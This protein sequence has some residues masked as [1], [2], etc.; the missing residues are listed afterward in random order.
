MAKWYGISNFG[1]H[2][3]IKKDVPKNIEKSLKKLGFYGRIKQTSLTGFISGDSTNK[4]LAKIPPKFIIS[5]GGG[6]TDV[7]QPLEKK[8]RI[9]RKI[10]KILIDYE[11]PA[12]FLT[13]SKLILRD[14]D[15]IGELNDRCYAN[16]AFSITQAEEKT[17]LLLE[18]YSSSTEDRFQVLRDFR[19]ANISGGVCLMPLAPFI[20]DTKE[21]LNQLLQM[22]IENK[23]DYALIAGLTLK[24][25][26][27]EVFFNN[28]IK[29]HYPDLLDR[30]NIIFPKNNTYGIPKIVEGIGL[31]N[32]TALGHDLC[33]K[34]GILPR[35]PRYIPEGNQIANLKVVEHLQYL[36][37][38][39]GW[40]HGKQNYEEQ[41]VWQKLSCLIESN[42]SL[43][44]ST[45]TDLERRSAFPGLEKI[46]HVIDEFLK[47]GDS[48]LRKKWD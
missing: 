21:N 42:Q 33:K 45:L 32:V 36:I 5:V 1:T 43:D 4:I 13:K 23:A 14:I 7:Y 18:P 28:I 11:I 30:Y 37:Y 2:I 20:G 17:R 16:I 31:V 9:T 34:Y 44:I 6:V 47:T 8:E 12:F 48:S 24:E 35:I 19:E 41:K 27:R 40:V 39:L 38:L 22:A 15:L 25:G 29:K 3:R 46:H 10:I 26:N